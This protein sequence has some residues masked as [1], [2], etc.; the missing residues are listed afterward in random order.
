MTLRGSGDIKCPPGGI[1]PVGS[2]AMRVEGVEEHCFR[3]VLGLTLMLQCWSAMCRAGMRS[4][5]A[6]LE[7]EHASPWL[8]GECRGSRPVLEL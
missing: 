2:T 7:P 8:D 4:T 3:S 6:C 5:Q 1:G